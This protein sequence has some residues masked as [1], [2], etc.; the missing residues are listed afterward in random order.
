M[1]NSEENIAKLNKYFEYRDSITVDIVDLMK[2]LAIENGVNIKKTKGVEIA[3]KLIPNNK[4]TVFIV[5]DGFGFYKLSKLDKDSIL[6]QNSK[7]RIKTVNPTSTAA[8]LT[9][10]VSVSYPNEHGIYGWWDYNRDYKLN[11]YPLLLEERKTGEKLKDKNITTEDIF[12]FV[13]VFDKFKTKVNIYEK[14]EIIN[15][16]YTK[17]FSKNATRHGFYSVKECFEKMAKNI[18]DE[19]DEKTF[20]YVYIDGIDEASHQNGVDSVEVS[21]IL[22]AVENGI[23]HLKEKVDDV[24]IV[25]TADHGQ[26]NMTSMLYLNKDMDFSKYFYALPSIDTRMISFFVKDECKK[27]FEEEFMKRFS[28]DVILL[29]KEEAKKYKLFGTDVYTK[30]A[31]KSLGEYIA[32]VVNNKFMVCD[33]IML[34][35]S[36]NTKGNHSGLTKEEITVPFVVI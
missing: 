19:A 9:S 20:N 17:M 6:K 3:K 31:D 14:R 28:E 25:L 35:D 32:V 26:V 11:Y 24:G 4:H 36:I 27:E 33:K 15:S 2:A 29:T 30:H 7:M 1:K 13:S 22:E 8:V 10:L 16:E 21:R 5:L 18:N 12:K 23:K 34:E